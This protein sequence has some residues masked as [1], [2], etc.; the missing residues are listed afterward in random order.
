[1]FVL[2]NPKRGPLSA[3]YFGD[4]KNPLRFRSCD[5]ITFSTEK[6]AQ[7]YRKYLVERGIS[8]AKNLICKKIIKK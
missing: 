1:M 7:I 2:S 3:C 4:P 6:E 8:G 5:W